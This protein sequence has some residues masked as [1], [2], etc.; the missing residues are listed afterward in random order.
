MLVDTSH[1]LVSN[2]NAG[3]G[4]QTRYECAIVPPS[5]F[6]RGNE[7]YF[8]QMCPLFAEITHYDDD[9][10]MVTLHGSFRLTSIGLSYIEVPDSIVPEPDENGMDQCDP[11]V[12]RSAD[13]SSDHESI[14]TYGTAEFAYIRWRN[15]GNY[16][17]S[18]P[19]LC[20][21][22]SIG[23]SSLND[24]RLMYDLY[25]DLTGA[26]TMLY[27]RSD[28]AFETATV[29]RWARSYPR[30]LQSGS[31][32]SN[33]GDYCS[34]SRTD[35]GPLSFAT[36]RFELGDP[37]GTAKSICDVEIPEFAR[38]EQRQ[39]IWATARGDYGSY[40][41]YVNTDGTLAPVSDIGT[42]WGGTKHYTNTDYIIH[43]EW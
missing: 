40:Q 39:T 16:R 14:S 4:G 34:V 31:S 1:M 37:G 33:I 41:I 29:T 5:E 13:T 8:D 23:P 2:A 28:L 7:R 10:D 24:S 36:I 26:S 11:M 21:T 38:P 19:A 43:S 9:S 6:V 17:L 18:R 42:T 35:V 22:D 30:Q 12:W 25:N 32:Y 20:N 15:S 3:G 27:R